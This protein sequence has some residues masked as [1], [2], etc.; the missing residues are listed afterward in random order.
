MFGSQ[1]FEILHILN[2][3][4]DYCIVCPQHHEYVNVAMDLK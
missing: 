4:K 1:L 3:F 2:Q